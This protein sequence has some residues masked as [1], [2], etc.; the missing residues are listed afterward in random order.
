MTMP[1]QSTSGA[2][3]LYTQP[4]LKSKR[5]NPRIDNDFVLSEIYFKQ[6]YFWTGEWQ[7]GEKEADEDI[8]LGR[9]KDF[10]TAKEMRKYLRHKRK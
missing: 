7:E 3:R 9:V 10:K 6:E 4:V 2:V 1:A 8:K 5:R